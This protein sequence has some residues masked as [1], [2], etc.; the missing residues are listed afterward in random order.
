MFETYTEKFTI[1]FSEVD[2][3]DQLKLSALFDFLQET[4]TN[5]TVQLGMDYE[6]L[7][8]KGVVW[9]LS[10]IKTEI[11]VYPK[12]QDVIYIETWSK[13]VNK[14][15]A[16]REFLVK[17]QQ[18]HVIGRVTSLWILINAEAKRPVHT[19]CLDFQYPI[20]NI[21]ALDASLSRLKPKNYN[22][23]SSRRISIGYTDLD[24]NRH[25]N[26]ARYIE[27]IFHCI[28]PLIFDENQVRSFQI[29]YLK[30]MTIS[31]KLELNSFQEGDTI[32]IIGNTSEERIFEASIILD[33]LNITRKKE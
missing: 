2:Y 14:Y 4:A 29:N 6:T 5:H 25:V 21:T 28:P 15:F 19:N 23:L 9:V 3:K 33:S 10:R 31:Q 32:I 24:M 27:Y 8:Q 12:Y 13:G 30:E 18:E 22:K 7:L 1:R 11:Y 20:V 26:N 17:D 16:Q